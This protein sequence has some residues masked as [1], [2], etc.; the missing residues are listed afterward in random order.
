MNMKPIITG[1][2]TGITAGAIAYAVSTAT[3]KEKRM[4]KC[5]AG[6][7]LHAMGDVMDGI[8]MIMK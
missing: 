3:N 6:K 2:S 5:R 1:I 4:L 7:A 8:S